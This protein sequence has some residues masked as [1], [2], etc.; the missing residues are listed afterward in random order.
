MWKNRHELLDV[1]TIGAS[2]LF[3][4]NDG[5]FGRSME[6]YRIDEVVRGATATVEDLRSETVHEVSATGPAGQ[7]HAGYRVRRWEGNHAP[8]L[9]HPHGSETLFDFGLFNSNSFRRIFRDNRSRMP[10]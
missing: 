9:L 8:T 6:S 1:A 5:F 3:V 7:F 4:R 10:T 2:A